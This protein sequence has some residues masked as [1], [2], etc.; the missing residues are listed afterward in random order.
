MVRVVIV[1]DDFLVAAGIGRVLR[2]AGADCRFV[3]DPRGTER[4]LEEVQPEL[5][6]CDLQMPG[7]SG[8]E[9][10]ASARNH[11]PAVRRCLLSGSL[12]LLRQEDVARIEPCVL[13]CKPWKNDE[14]KRLLLPPTDLT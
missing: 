4:V 9:V 14:L 1:E 10:L 12:D 8:V 2:T 3:F 13:L 11:F 5:L 7:R 6:I